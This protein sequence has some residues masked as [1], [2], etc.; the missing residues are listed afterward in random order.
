[1]PDSAATLA[2]GLDV[3]QPPSPDLITGHAAQQIE[4]AAAHLWP[5]TTVRLGRIIPSVT[6]HVQEVDVDGLPW[7]A[8]YSILGSSLVSLLRGSC[9]DWPTIQRAQAQYA[10]APDTLVM[11]E[12]TQLHALGDAG[13]AVPA[14]RVARGVLFTE[15]VPGTT[16]TDRIAAEPDRTAEL[17]ATV[18]RALAAPLRDERTAALVD[19]LP[20]P[21]RSISGTFLRK[22]NGISG[23]C[24]LAQIPYGGVLGRVV[25]RLRRA[26]AGPALL[27]RPV[28][29]GDLKPEHVIWPDHGGGPLFIDP[30]LMRSQ[31][32]ADLAK[33]V[34]RLVLGLVTARAPGDH[35]RAVLDGITDHV[36]AEASAQPGRDRATWLHQTATLWLMDTT[37]IVTT[38]L[39]APTGLPLPLHGTALIARASTIVRM[40][41]QASTRL[42]HGD[43][44]TSVWRAC[45]DEAAQAAAA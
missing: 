45:V 27:D 11:R 21:E 28:V 42:D 25:P 16:L 38:C 31:P 43:C 35:T 24:Y 8:K 20:I 12:A 7:I 40:L 19:R 33:L 6:S 23:P 22:F 1:M 3:V 30:G 29:Y 34:S 10:A 2:G 37:N 17:L 9:G 14:A 13:L 26:Y 44:S 36:L 18:T 15:P 41:D 32:C 5:A 4:A 39:S